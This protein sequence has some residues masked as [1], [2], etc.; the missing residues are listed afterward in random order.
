MKRKTCSHAKNELSRFR[1]QSRIA[2]CDQGFA[3]KS[4]IFNDPCFLKKNA[5][6]ECCLQGWDSEITCT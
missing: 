4:F 1:T 3:A 2:Q 6:C 5:G